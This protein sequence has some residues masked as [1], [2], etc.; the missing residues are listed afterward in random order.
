MDRFLYVIT[1]I[2]MLSIWVLSGFYFIKA[3]SSKI[4]QKTFL[5][6]AI[7]SFS[8][9]ILYIVHLLLIYL[10]VGFEDW[11]F[12]N[13]MPYANV[14][15]FMFAVSPL[16]LLLPKRVRKHCL[17]LISL[18]TIGM[19]I[20]PLISIIHNVVINYKYHASFLLDYVPHL[21]F[22]I[23]GIYIIQSKQVVLNIK[24]STISGSIIMCVALLMMILNVI[25]DQSFFGLSLNGKHSIYNQKIVSN[26]Y[27]SALV[28]FLGLLII[29][30]MGYLF[31]YF[32][33]K[34]NKKA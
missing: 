23:W 29:M 10:D 26:S 21:I 27:V 24:S 17:N 8:A 2:I 5:L 4:L 15:P 1:L 12:Q 11:N 20:S 19:I 16:F 22:S 6:N 33:I 3:K 31:H 9:F 25:F 18:L 34:I 7:F 32:V 13:A 28:Y 30:I 14:S